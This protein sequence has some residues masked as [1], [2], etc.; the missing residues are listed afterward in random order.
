MGWCR[1]Y[2]DVLGDLKFGAI[3]SDTGLPYAQ[4]VG[5]WSL[6]LALANASPVRGRLMLAGHKKMT[7]RNVAETLH[8]TEAETEALFHTFRD[9]EM[10]ST[11]PEGF[12]YITNWDKR[13]FESDTSTERVRKHREMKRR[14]N[15]S[16]TDQTIPDHTIPDHTSSTADDD[17]PLTLTQ[18]M[19]KLMPLK[20][21]SHVTTWLDSQVAAYG[22]EAV[23]V[24]IND[25]LAQDHLNAPMKW[26]NEVLKN[27]RAKANAKPKPDTEDLDHAR[28]AA[29]LALWKSQKAGVGA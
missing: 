4:V 7:P 3:A 5:A 16:V 29:A 21:N 28:H 8:V 20:V 17:G 24:A 13:Q 6:V 19:D 23:R 9:Y 18:L 22:E 15:V 1:W 11:D 2:D 25:A 12:D 14:G 27:N 10:I 26:I